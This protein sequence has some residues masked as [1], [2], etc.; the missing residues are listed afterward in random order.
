MRIN[1]YFTAHG[2]LSR[3]EADRLIEA[4]RVSINGRTAK[5]GDQV[6]DGDQVSLDGQNVATAKPKPVVLAYN[7]PVGVECTSDERVADNI[8]AAVNYSERLFHVG[9]LD[10]MSEG[11]I[12]LTNVGDFVNAALRKEHGHEKE[13]HVWF[14][15][16]IS[17]NQIELLR[18]G[19]EL[20][21]GPTLPAGVERLSDNRVSLTLTEGRNR[22]IRRMAEALGL[23]VSRLMRV[24]F[25]N[26]KLG[27]LKIGE[28]RALK[29][30]EL[31][32]LFDLTQL[33]IG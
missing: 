5:L 31:M 4:G 18:K 9:R 33:S 8:I 10:K 7:K 13:Y 19:V 22:Q 32:A 17:D 1:R 29:D 25:L 21:D 11:L 2:I 20:D 3:R 24:R 6:Q 14:N 23:R 16:Q 28:W 12:L 26:L 15:D 30:Y 27:S